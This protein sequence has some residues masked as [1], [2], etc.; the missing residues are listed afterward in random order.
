MAGHGAQKLFGSFGG[1]GLKGTSGFMEMLGM[2]PGRP[3][4]VPHLGASDPV[5]VLRGADALYVYG[6]G[7]TLA[8]EVQLRDELVGP[9]GD[10]GLPRR[11]A[12][13]MVVE[14]PLGATLRVA[15]G[16]HADVHGVDGRFGLGK[17]PAS[18]K[19][20]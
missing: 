5:G 1:P 12:R 13:R 18:E 16:P 14:T 20:P 8:H 9:S 6:R 19:S 7:P 15:S 10:D 4:A 2:R 17:R 11:V 3:W